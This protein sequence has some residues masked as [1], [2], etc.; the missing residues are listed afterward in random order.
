MTP[1]CL[2]AHPSH[3]LEL[4]ITFEDGRG[5]T[6]AVSAATVSFTTSHRLAIG[7]RIRGTIRFPSADD[8]VTTI[9]HYD[10]VVLHSRPKGADATLRRIGARFE[11]LSF[12]S[13][14]DLAED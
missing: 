5:I 14:T 2:E 11:R 1:D 7:Q 6:C 9:V 4:P 10:A 13:E 3:D 12:A 8:A